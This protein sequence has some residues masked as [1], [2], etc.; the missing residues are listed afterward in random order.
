MEAMK[1]IPL[2]LEEGHVLQSGET[3]ENSKLII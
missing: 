2:E 3:I 1:A